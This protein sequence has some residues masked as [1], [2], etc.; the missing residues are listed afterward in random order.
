LHAGEILCITGLVG[1]KRTELVRALF[2]ADRF[3][4]GKLEVNGRSVAFRCPR[5]S[6]AAG[7][8]FVPEDRHQDGLMLGLSVQANLVMAT[9][10]RFL[11]GVLLDRRAM[12]ANARRWIAQLNI[13][14]PDE[15]RMVRHLSGGNQQKVL[16]GK[17]LNLVPN[18]L[19]L[20]EPTVGVDVGA[21]AEIYGFLRAERNRGTAILVVSSDLEEV[22]TISDRIA[23][24]ASG[25]IVS[26]RDADGTST[27]QI[28]RDIGG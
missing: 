8:A 26:I 15:R 22:M 10:G 17:S 14:P 9:I 21:K 16:L 5:Q 1:S 28:V 19:I 12:A 3:D 2:G 18:I 4:D 6:I 27:S 20:D 11:R 7:I 24:M 25:R 23:V 13:Q